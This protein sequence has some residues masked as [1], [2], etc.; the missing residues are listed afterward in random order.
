MKKINWKALLPHVI[1]IVIFAVVAII[2]CKPAFEGKVLQQDDTTQWKSMAQSSFEFK[3]KNGHFPLWTNSMFSGMP[4]YQIAMEPEN[5]LSLEPVH[6]LLQLGLPN[7]AH[8]FF[9]AC[10]CFYFLAIVLRCNPFIAIVTALSYAYCTYN[11]I[12]IAAGHQTKMLAI[13]YL[14]ALVGAIILLFNK[15]YIVGTALTA[16]T[17]A[18]LIQANHL[19]ITYYALI[20]IVFMS[21]GFL[22]NSIKNK[23][24]KHLLVAGG[25]ALLAAMIGV[26][27]NAV[28]LRTT[29]EYGKLSIRGGSILADSNAKGNV[30]KTGLNK[31]YAFSYSLYK[32][33]PLAMLVPHIY[34]GSS[35]LEVEESKSKAIEKLQEN[36]K[37]LQYMV[38]LKF[39]QFHPNKHLDSLVIAEPFVGAFL[40]I[41][42]LLLI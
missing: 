22:I 20:I 28:V 11:P 6:H 5:P 40:V 37:L 1:A 26:G 31:D 36:I 39:H 35:S 10:I 12:I 14:P 19:Q 18:L 2:Y 29:S 34:G 16:L 7:P 24:F 4:A 23:E 27:V 17:T 30:T 9:L 3:E 33:E 15:K 8:F 13:A 38:D 41:F 25:L 32:T 21:V 42:Q